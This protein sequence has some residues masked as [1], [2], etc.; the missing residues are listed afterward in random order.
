MPFR[1]VR[2]DVS[3]RAQ[4]LVRADFQVEMRTDRSS[5]S[6]TIGPRQHV[7]FD[8]DAPI[9]LVGAAS[10]TGPGLVS[11]LVLTKGPVRTRTVIAN[12][13]QAAEV[14]YRDAFYGG[15]DPGTTV[16]A[17][18]TYNLLVNLAAGGQASYPLTFSKKA[19]TD[20][21]AGAIVITNPGPAQSALADAH[22]G[23]P[24]S[25]QW[26]LPTAYTAVQV[27][28]DGWVN[29]AQFPQ[30]YQ[31]NIDSQTFAGSAT[32]ATMTIPSLCNGLLVISGGI[33]LRAEGANGENS[34]FVH[35]FADQQTGGSTTTTTTTGST[36]TTTTTTTTGST[37]TTTLGAVV[38]LANLMSSFAE[39]QVS[40]W[41]NG[42]SRTWGHPYTMIDG[43]QV[44]PRRQEG[45][46]STSGTLN[47]PS[48]QHLSLDGYG[49]RQHK[50][51]SA[52]GT[53]TYSPARV[54]VPPTMNLGQTIESVHTQTF[55]SAS[56][57]AIT[58]STIKDRTTAM[59]IESVDTPL[60]IFQAVKLRR[61]TLTAATDGSYPAASTVAITDSWYGTAD[62]GLV[63]LVTRNP[64]GTLALSQAI[65]RHD[66]I[67]AGGLSTGAT[68]SGT[69]ISAA[70]V[71]SPFT[72]GTV[73]L[74]TNGESRTWG[75]PY[76]LTGGTQVYPRL[77]QGGVSTS[78]TLNL[79]NVLHLSLDGNGMLQHKT[80]STN[81][82]F[83]YSPPR[84]S[85]PP[86]MTIGQTIESIHTQT[87]VSAVTGATTTS[88]IKDVTAV[89][90]LESVV[91]PLGTFQAIKLS[92]QTFVAAADGSY[93]ASS[94]VPTNDYWYGVGGAGLVKVVTRNPD[95]TVALSQTIYAHDAITIRGLPTGATLSGTTIAAADVVSPAEGEVSLWTNGESRTTGNPSNLS[96]GAQMFPRLIQGGVSTSGTL[97]IPSFQ[98]FAL[99]VNGGRLY[100]NEST[101]GITT[102]SPARVIVPPTMTIGQ[103]LEL[104]YTQVFVAATNGATTTSTI[105][106]LITVV[107]IESV[108]TPLG[109]FHAIKLSRQ[110]LT[111]ASDGSYPPASNMSTNYFWYG[112]GGAG[113]VKQEVRNPDGTVALSQSLFAVITKTSGS[114]TTTTTTGGTTTTT[115]TGGTTTSTTSSTTTTLGGSGGPATLNFV[116]GWNLVGNSSSGSLDVAGAFGD[117]NKVT[118]VWKWIASK[119]N[120][121]FYTPTQP[122]GG[123]A[124]AAGKSYDFLTSVSGGEGFWVNAKN[125]FSAQLP[126]GSAISSASFQSMGSGW[127]LIAIGD[128]KTP[129]GFNNSLS[130]TP[131]SAGDIPQ[132]IISLWAWDAVQGNWY[133]YAPDRDKAGTLSSYVQTK[134]YLDF[135]TKTLGPTMG[136]WVNRP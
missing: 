76:T 66:T 13:A 43:T 68:F 2:I 31:C 86:T 25:V 92:R 47:M 119:S 73:T 81:G 109:T 5:F 29:T 80:E 32:S 59:G 10:V 11:P 128:D 23:S 82:T 24:R 124:Y 85:V 35:G 90:G 62:G 94:T 105:K 70:D 65:F 1:A 45:A 41:T 83:T 37:T 100:E 115:T 61:Q 49:L 30:G 56:N 79:S 7:N 51:E 28:L 40:L 3:S 26:T 132:N 108:E 21:V 120:W 95:G 53:S 123:A 36:T 22:M 72:E 39:G 69:T 101:S 116:P 107:G 99:D 54:M 126:S 52:N 14:I 131:P 9:G 118:T 27:Y 48:V 16:Q 110:T 20:P 106:D 125:S 96:G 57:G 112:G 121:A 42:E 74:W 111:A 113:L 91:T 127:N 19:V 88:T 50:I 55:V 12:P 134:Q 78:G 38:S 60:G 117:A 6:T 129:K 122:D 71:T 63:K 130:L 103:T 4:S 46:V 75:H 17:G 8:V 102:F 104:S 135:G 58:T 77:V 136:F 114:S 89:V 67:T 44:F 33:F 133:F 93:A 87:F 18:T 64:D 34:V 97:I 98:H 84:V 15:F